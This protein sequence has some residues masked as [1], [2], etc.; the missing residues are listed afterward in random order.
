MTRTDRTAVVTGSTSGIGRAVAVRLLRD[1][2][3][4]VLN[5]STDEDRAAATL[6][7]CRQIAPDVIL[8]KADVSNAEQASRL[9]K[10]A[11]DEFGSV[12]VLVNNAAC[13]IDRPV[14]EMTEDEWDRVVDVD[15]KGAFLCSQQAARQML[16]QDGGGVILNIGASTGIRGR[17]NGANTCAAKAGLMVLTQCLALE[18]APKVRVNTVIP[19][20]TETEETQRR[21]GLDD[22]AAR[23]ARSGQIPLGRLGRP[24]DVA[25]V[26]AFLLSD[27]AGFVTGQRVVVD[28]GQNMW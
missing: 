26:V 24:E 21:F 3:R 6:G 16:S 1:G 11:V 28:G 8:V 13:V 12:D 18:L 17:R 10:R 2:C 25:D 22:P 5:Y 4:V 20:L 7:A 23:R 14:L 27:D 19:G 15:L 9:I